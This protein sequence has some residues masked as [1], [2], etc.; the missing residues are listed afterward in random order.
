MKFFHFFAILYCKM[1]FSAHIRR[2]RSAFSPRLSHFRTVR[3]KEG[4]RLVKACFHRYNKVR[5]MIRIGSVGAIRFGRSM[6]RTAVSGTANTGS[7]P[8]RSAK[9]GVSPDSGGDALFLFHH[10]GTTCA[11][12]GTGRGSRGGDRQDAS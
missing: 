8:V 6:D 5:G 11:P 10:F 9:K 4:T 12:S 7:T 2:N 1:Y 3:K